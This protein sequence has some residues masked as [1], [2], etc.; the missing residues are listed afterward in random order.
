MSI[1]GWHFWMIDTI[2]DDFKKSLAHS[3]LP[4]I[5]GFSM[6]NMW[7][8]G[9]SWM[10][11]IGTFPSNSSKN[12]R[13]VYLI[14]SFKPCEIMAP[15]CSQPLWT[16][17]SL[18]PQAHMQGLPPVSLC[19]CSSAVLAL[20]MSLK[21]RSPYRVSSSEKKMLNLEVIGSWTNLL[22]CV[23]I[24]Q[25]LKNIIVWYEQHGV[26]DRSSWPKIDAVF[27]SKLSIK[28]SFSLRT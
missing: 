5:F 11:M 1:S 28:E 13:I 14:L 15:P 10:C 26:F 12:L 16:G 21:P 8:S 7:A 19:H 22:K 17:V 6:E 2:S 3:N 24:Y 25:K 27:G 9:T 20:L 4:L 18:L 23:V